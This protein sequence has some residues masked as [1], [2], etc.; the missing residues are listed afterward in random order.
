MDVFGFILVVTAATG[1]PQFG[2]LRPRR[3]RLLLD[4]RV[5]NSAGEGDE[6]TALRRSSPGRS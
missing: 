5:D 4:L 1:T 3:A 2:G 6:N